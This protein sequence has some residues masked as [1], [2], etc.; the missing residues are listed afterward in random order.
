MYVCV[1]VRA[2]V[3]VRACARAFVCVCLCVCVCVFVLWVRA[4]MH[5]CYCAHE[6]RRKVKLLFVWQQQQTTSVV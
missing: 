1:C 2:C 6:K 5:T 3:R 4:P